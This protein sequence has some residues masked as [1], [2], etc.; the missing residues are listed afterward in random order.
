MAN[1][2]SVTLELRPETLLP[3][4]SSD[5]VTINN[6]I[7]RDAVIFFSNLAWGPV[8]LG[9]VRA[10]NSITLPT[11]VNI[12]AYARFDEGVFVR[13]ETFARYK[14]QCN[15]KKINLTPGQTYSLRD[16]DSC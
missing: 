9:Y 12:D 4:G 3:Q 2:K 11:A 10:G 8:S 14:I 6:N 5:G 7:G 16:F 13:W 1:E 15:K